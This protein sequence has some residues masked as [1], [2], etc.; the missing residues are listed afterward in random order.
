MFSETTNDSRKY[1][2]GMEMIWPE[3]CPPQ[4]SYVE[5]LTPSVTALGDKT[6]NDIIQVK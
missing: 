4:N 1:H 3:L 5:A 6:F 2:I